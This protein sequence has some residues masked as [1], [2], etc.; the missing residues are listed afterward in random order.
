MGTAAGFKIAVPDAYTQSVDGMVA[1]LNRS[2]RNFHIAVNLAAWKYV[3]SLREAQYLEKQASDSH[4]DFKVLLL[5][6]IGFK[7]VAYRSGSAA[8]LKY[9]WVNATTG[10]AYTQLDIL[11]TLSTASGDQPY[12]F[13]VW[14]PSATFSAATGTFHTALKTFRVVPA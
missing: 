5:E 11:V 13:S 12:T 14:A 2:A 1:H 10:V 6:S 3:K 4:N 8:E 9:S 7:S